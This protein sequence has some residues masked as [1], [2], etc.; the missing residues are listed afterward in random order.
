MRRRL[1]KLYRLRQ[2]FQ[3]VNE[4]NFTDCDA[5]IEQ[6][7]RVFLKFALIPSWFNLSWK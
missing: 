7:G 1:H 4:R 5:K 2:L 6:S 3:S